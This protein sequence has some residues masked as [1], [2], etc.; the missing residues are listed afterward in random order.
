MGRV[1]TGTPIRDVGATHDRHPGAVHL[2][3]GDDAIIRRITIAREWARAREPGRAESEFADAVR[4]HPTDPRSWRAYADWYV[5]RGRF[6]RAG[7][8]LRKGIEAAPRNASQRPRSIVRPSA[9]ISWAGSSPRLAR[10][11]SDSTRAS[12]SRVPKGFVT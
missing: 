8:L 9:T 2:F 10:R 11:D 5:R 12:S 1:P 3:D 7:T 4:A 6:G